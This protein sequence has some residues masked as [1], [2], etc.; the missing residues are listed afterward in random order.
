MPQL[1][2]TY[3]GYQIS[4][5]YLPDWH[6]IRGIVQ[7]SGHFQRFDLNLER[8]EM[9]PQ[10]DGLVPSPIT[11]NFFKWGLSCYVDGLIT[12]IRQAEQPTRR[13]LG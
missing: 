10:S 8:S 11:I 7:G 5:E 2:E 1:D 4:V 12:S 9:I 6:T 13:L 3:R